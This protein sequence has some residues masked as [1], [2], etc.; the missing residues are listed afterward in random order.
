MRVFTQFPLQFPL[1][2]FLLEASSKSILK[3]LSDLINTIITRSQSRIPGSKSQ[4]TSIHQT[5][6]VVDKANFKSVTVLLILQKCL[7]ECLTCSF[8]NILRQSFMTFMKRSR[9]LKRNVYDNCLV[10]VRVKKLSNAF[11]R[12]DFEN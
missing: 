5:D 2:I 1:I 7:K 3:A 4:I 12:L 8:Q 10:L 9:I 11:G 6:S